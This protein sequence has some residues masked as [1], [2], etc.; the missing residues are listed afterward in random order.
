MDIPGAPQT[1][2]GVTFVVDAIVFS[3][4][5]FPGSKCSDGPCGM[6]DTMTNETK[7][8]ANTVHPS[9]FRVADV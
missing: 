4:Y 3:E 5:I 6:V 8:R 2:S 9:E 1:L 7:S